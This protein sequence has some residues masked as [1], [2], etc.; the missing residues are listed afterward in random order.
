MVIAVT[1]VLLSGVTIVL[2]R[3][4]NAKLAQTCGA[5]YSSLMNYIT[6]LLGSLA[7]FF[8][9]GAAARA[10]FPAENLSLAAYLGGALGLL[11]VYT[12]NRITHRLPA[13]QL[14]L[15]IFLGQLFSGLLLDYFATHKFSPG[16]VL[17]GLLVLAGL[18]V[19][20]LGDRRA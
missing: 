11:S 6:G 7:V 16:T 20:S 17:G 9:T 13:T 5:P 4:C 1:G 14:T 15:L 10:A 19:N 8:V 3:M 12:L 18:A 2:A